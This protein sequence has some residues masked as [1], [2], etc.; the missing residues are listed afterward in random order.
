VLAEVLHRPIPI[1]ALTHEQALATR[2]PQLPEATF[3]VLL[4]VMAAA[5]DI[6]AVL[7]NNVERITG[8]PART[9][10]EWAHAN[11]DAF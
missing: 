8:H 9:F 4:E 11:R 5:V 6:P 7:N 1:D 3:E 10:R 2:P